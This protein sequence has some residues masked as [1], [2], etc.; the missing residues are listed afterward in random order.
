MSSSSSDVGQPKQ[1]NVYSLR[2]T[3]LQQA[4]SVRSV[5]KNAA[6]LLPYLQPGMY[7]VD[8]GCGPGSITLGLA[9]YITPGQVIGIDIEAAQIE[10]TNALAAERGVTNARFETGSAYALPFDAA[11]VD[12]IYS[13][14]MMEHLS[15]PMAALQE[16]YRILK[17]GG[18]IGIRAAED[19]GNIFYPYNPESIKW[20][21][22]SQQLHIE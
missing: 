2:G 20:R 8:C 22:W 19:D 3:K 13:N 16:M 21:Q 4:M 18:V 12:A 1:E 9:A 15:D 5:E 17:P 14:A 10:R 11:A 7:L 6:F